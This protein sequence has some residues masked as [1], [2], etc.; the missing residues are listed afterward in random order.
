MKQN[1][2]ECIVIVSTIADYKVNLNFKVNEQ[3]KKHVISYF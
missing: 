2:D 1:T 3:N